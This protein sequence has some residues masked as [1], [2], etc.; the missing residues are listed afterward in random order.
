MS[1]HARTFPGCRYGP[2]AL[3]AEWRRT[4]QPGERVLGFGAADTAGPGWRALVLLTPAMPVGGVW[5]G[6][7]LK[8]RRVLVLTDRRLM[9]L[10]PDRAVLD[11][12]SA[13]WNTQYP[14][15]QI[16]IERAGSRSV[17]VRTPSDRFTVR[18]RGAWSGADLS[19]ACP[20]IGG[21]ENAR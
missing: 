6:R 5:S 19:T 12:R 7:L 10:A 16:A 1:G 8:R 21:R 9:V 17:R 14:L 13:R 3:R 4:L 11:R 2:M 20:A 18:L 15:A